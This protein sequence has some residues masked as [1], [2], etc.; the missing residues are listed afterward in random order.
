[1]N[2]GLDDV[3]VPGLLGLA[4]GKAVAARRR[5]AALGQA[6]AD[7]GKA[8][9]AL[10]DLQRAILLQLLRQL[11]GDIFSSL[12]WLIQAG[13]EDEAN[14]GGAA[15]VNLSP[16]SEARL[17]SLMQQRGL[18]TD[19]DLIEAVAH[20]L[21]QHQLEKATRPPDRNRWTNEPTLDSPWDFFD[22]ELSEFS[23]VCR[24]IA[25][26]VVDRSRRTDSFGNPVLIASEM[27]PELYRRLHWRIAAVLRH[28][29]AE[30]HGDDPG[31][32]DARIAA[33]CRETIRHSQA[34]AAVPGSASEAARAM[35]AAGLSTM[36]TVHRLLKAGEIPLFE[37]TFARIAG[38][39]PVLLR[40][41]IYEPGGV[42]FAILARALDVDMEQA[43]SILGLI[44]SG[45]TKQFRESNGRID[46]LKAVYE[47]VSPESAN[48][49]RA[50]WKLEP[51]FSA[52]LWQADP[53]RQE[54]RGNTLH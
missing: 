13:N 35:E 4:H 25:A 29:L 23:P 51:E 38:I 8:D 10:T 14:N 9:I 34:I 28:M 11:V 46:P 37:E 50:H 31:S 33:A 41:L 21:Y 2:A 24:R 45:G 53:A 43:T 22:Q 17:F 44:R 3:S 15:R 18:L 5:Y 19:C 32:L 49:I 30:E 52:A 12:R 27:E 40:R 47:A 6:L 20:R 42:C 1:M 54:A 36:E 39:R 26:Y 16:D 7:S 48:S